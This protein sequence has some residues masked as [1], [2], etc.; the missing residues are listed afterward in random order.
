[1]LPIRIELAATGVASCRV[2]G[3]VQIESVSL[4]ELLR[5]SI[6]G[7]S[8]RGTHIQLDD[9]CKQ[10]GLPTS[11]E[12]SKR[13]RMTASYDAAS[14]ADLP[15]VAENFLNS[16]PPSP[17]R[18]N[19]IQDAVWATRNLPEIPLRFRHE[20]SRALGGAD[21]LFLR[22]DAFEQL[23]ERLWVIDDPFNDFL[24]PGRLS[25][26]RREIHQHI[27]KNPDDWS[28]ECVF[29]RLGAF[30]ASNGRFK[31][32]IE[33]LAS[34]RVRPDIDSQHRFV[35]R[36][37]D[38]IRASGVELRETE[39]EGG[40]PVYQLVWVSRGLQGK[41][42]NIIF[43]SPFK[44][45]LRFRDAL[46]NDIEI[47]SNAEAVLVYDRP[48]A[49]DGLC[50]RDLQEWWAE[51]ERVAA[52]EAKRSLY[53]RLMESLPSNSPAQRRVFTGYAKHFGSAVP[54]L[55]ALLPEVWLHWDP[56]TVKERG[57]K[58]LLRFR[59]DFLMLLPN[60]VRVVI[61][62]D[63]KHHYSDENG[64]ASSEKY[65]L[66]MSA[67][68][69]LRLAGYDVYRFGV[70]ELGSGDADSKVAE[71]FDQLFRQYHVPIPPTL[72]AAVNKGDSEKR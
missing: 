6:I 33:G 52:D 64:R 37:N 36:V 55:P 65:G 71:F 51:R 50:W 16:F 12:G 10:L 68:R 27:F 22:A 17:E 66:M 25:G 28:A 62:V 5:G 32:F 49:A 14:D 11:T 29:E 60:N 26:L 72:R 61:E 38:V 3:Y 39:T 1:M 57:P 46:N 15:K 47:V 8:Q 19:A 43:A 30:D 35:M 53:R 70:D 34:A 31:L 9:F 41:P 67:D 42:K 7:L 21:E 54:D 56:K 20:L 24:D 13:D 40:Y 45:D 23:L 18:R 48:I 69:D 63:G 58:A 2:T 59:M 44:P 4:R